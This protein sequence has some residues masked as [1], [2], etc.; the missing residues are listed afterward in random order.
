MGKMSEFFGKLKKVKHIEIIAGAAAIVLVLVV[1]FACASCTNKE[2]A[3]NTS[4]D[5]IDAD[6]CT[7]MQIR[8]EKIISE[9]DGVGSAS[10]VINWDRSVPTTVMGGGTEN[11]KATGVLVVCDGGKSTKVQLDIIYA[12]STLLDLSIDKVSVYPKS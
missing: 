3:A 10:V 2:K 11:P 1:Y 4:A 7:A 12:V 6:Y 5:I 9:I 8:L